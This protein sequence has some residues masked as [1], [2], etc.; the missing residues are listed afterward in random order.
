MLTIPKLITPFHIERAIYCGCYPRPTDLRTT[1]N[2]LAGYVA[3]AHGDQPDAEAEHS[4]GNHR[5][6]SGPEDACRERCPVEGED[7]QV[8][9]P[10]GPLEQRA[11][12]LYEVAGFGH[13]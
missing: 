6:Q 1:C 2:K 7:R 10:A 8:E 11:D 12:L 4:D 9:R 5:P 13:Q 3:V